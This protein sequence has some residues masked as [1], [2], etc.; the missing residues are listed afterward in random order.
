MKKNTHRHED[1]LKLIHRLSKEKPVHGVDLSRALGVSKPTVSV[2]LKEMTD[3][4]YITVEKHHVICLTAKGLDIAEATQDRHE[5][6]CSLLESLGVPDTIAAADAC[7]IE[8]DLSPQSYEALKRLLQEHSG[9]F[10]E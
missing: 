6:L 9:V 1:Y 5:T 3:A 8:H 2:F 4:G 7:A 10:E